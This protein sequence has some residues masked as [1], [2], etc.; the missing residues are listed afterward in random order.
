MGAAFFLFSIYMI[1]PINF[2]VFFISSSSLF[3]WRDYFVATSQAEPPLENVNRT[4][5]KLSSF[6]PSRVKVAWELET[7]PTIA[8]GQNIYV[9]LRSV[10]EKRKGKEKWKRIFCIIHV[11]AEY[12]AIKQPLIQAKNLKIFFSW[13]GFPFF[14]LESIS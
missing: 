9:H 8:F 7:N 14:L 12:H 3:S 5:K 6:R 2:S 4:T 1:T 11:G 13:L 10:Q